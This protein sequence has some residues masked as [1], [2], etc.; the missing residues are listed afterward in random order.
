MKRPE[1]IKVGAMSYKV[2]YDKAALDAIAVLSHKHLM[3]DTSHLHLLM[4]IDDTLPEQVIR[5]TL[6]HETLHTLWVSG[7][8]GDLE[9]T[10]EQL[11]SALTPRL[12]SVLRDNPVLA[13]YL[14]SEKEQ[15]D[16]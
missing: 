3:G 16:E 6:L 1:T 5:D 4:T 15:D 10:Q 12:L 2:V 8:F 13:G 9:M 14:V 11:V 7:G